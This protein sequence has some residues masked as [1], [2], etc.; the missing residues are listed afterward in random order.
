MRVTMIVTMAIGCF[1]AAMTVQMQAS[2][3][4]RQK[5]MNFCGKSV[6]IFVEGPAAMRSAVC[7]SH[8]FGIDVIEAGCREQRSDCRPRA[9]AGF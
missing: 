9:A 6:D 1:R 4:D 3:A 5:R 2:N 7:V 8:A